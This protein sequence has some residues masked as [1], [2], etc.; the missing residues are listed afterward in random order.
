M[1]AS[2]KEMVRCMDCKHGTYMQWF[3]NPVICVCAVHEEKFVA[4][5]R[6][7]CG[8]F[9]RREGEAEITHYDS[10]E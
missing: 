5:S 1:A 9:V 4:E 6:R 10:Y 2:N 8:D 7:I 3:R